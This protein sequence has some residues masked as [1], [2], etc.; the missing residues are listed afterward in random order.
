MSEQAIMAPGELA[1]QIE[2]DHPGWEVWYGCSSWQFM[3]LHP[4]VPRMLIAR[5][6]TAMRSLIADW[7][8]WFRAG[9]A[10]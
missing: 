1:R 2:A 3:A 10:M 7:E 5:S 9:R 4:N 8:N 6:D